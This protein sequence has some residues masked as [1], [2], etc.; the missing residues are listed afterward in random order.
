MIMLMTIRKTK[1]N[2]VTLINYFQQHQTKNKIDL[3]PQIIDTLI[4]QKTPLS[5]VPRAS[6]ESQLAV[7]GAASALGA[8]RQLYEKT[9]SA[10][11]SDKNAGAVSERAKVF[12]SSADK[13]DAA[14]KLPPKPS[15][16]KVINIEQ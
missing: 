10:A 13:N 2:K 3:Y 9:K 7:A 6:F 5:M 14:E 12:G 15:A 11:S 8:G 1:I 16:K 4:L